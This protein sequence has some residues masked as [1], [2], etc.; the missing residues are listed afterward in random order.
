MQKRG[1]TNGILWQSG[2]CLVN[3]KANYQNTWLF[4]PEKLLIDLLSLLFSTVCGTNQ[5]VHFHQTPNT[6]HQR[7]TLLLQ[8][9][10]IPLLFNNLAGFQYHSSHLNF[11]KIDTIEE[12]GQI[13]SHIPLKIWQLCN[14][15]RIRRNVLSKYPLIRLNKLVYFGFLTLKRFKTE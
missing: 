14:F 8:Y 12:V 10:S 9:L 13:L 15:K 7:T 11:T 4:L 2:D 5:V 6:K 3:P 1:H